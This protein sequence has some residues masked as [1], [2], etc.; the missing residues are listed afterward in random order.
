MS[1]FQREPENDYLIVCDFDGTIAP[2]DVTDA[3]LE[4]FAHPDWMTVEQEW[5]EG[6]ITA[7]ECME[8]QVRLL[9]V[10]ENRLDAFLDTIPLTEGFRDFVEQC[11][12]NGREMIIVSDGID[13]SIKRILAKHDITNIPVIANRLRHESNSSYKL[14]FPYHTPGCGSGV[15]KCTVASMAEKPIVLIGDSHS[16]LCLAGKADH[17]MAKQDKILLAHCKEHNIPH[18]PYDDFHD[19]VHAFAGLPPLP[20]RP[21]SQ[22]IQAARD[23]I[24]S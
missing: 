10:S 18:H 4:E 24:T 1:I 9:S 14:E 7:M 13:Y 3:V 21:E 22:K 8:R 16:D 23:T 5:S 20:L 2:F 11:R 12:L 17:V 6:R 19:I 15:C